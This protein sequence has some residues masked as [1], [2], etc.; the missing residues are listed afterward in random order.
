MSD[1]ESGDGSYIPEMGAT[2]TWKFPSGSDNQAKKFQSHFPWF[3]FLVI[4]VEMVM[5]LVSIGLQDGFVS[6]A[7]NPMGGAGFTVLQTMGGRWFPT[8][9]SG[10]V[11]LLFSSMY[12]QHP[13]PFSPYCVPHMLV[14]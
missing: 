2:A 5:L 6:M 12:E 3:S 7:T 10:H 14:L 13:V 9:R 4:T 11:Y 1:E 8:I